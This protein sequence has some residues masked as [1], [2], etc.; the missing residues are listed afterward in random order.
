MAKR[1]ST[2]KRKPNISHDAGKPTRQF[3]SRAFEEAPGDTPLAQAEVDKVGFTAPDMIAGI[4]EQEKEVLQAKNDPTEENLETEIENK[5]QQAVEEEKQ[6]ACEV[7]KDKAI[8]TEL[9]DE[10]EKTVEQEADAKEAEEELAKSENELAYQQ[11]QKI[12]EKQ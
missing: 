1:T 12:K 6:V 7:E 5:S 11:E 9:A 2:K 8:Q 3:E 10:T 4:A